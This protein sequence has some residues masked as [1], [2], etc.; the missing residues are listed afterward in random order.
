[1]RRS[2]WSARRIN[3]LRAW[4]VQMAKAAILLDRAAN[5]LRWAQFAVIFLAQ[6]CTAYTSVIPVATLGCVLVDNDTCA[7]LQISGIA[8]AIIG[9][10]VA[11]MDGTIGLRGIAQNMTLASKQINQLARKIDIQLQ[12]DESAR[13]SVDVFSESVAQ[14]YDEIMNTV[15]PLPR[16]I[17]HRE[18]L[19]NLTLLSA[20]IDAPNTLETRP[21]DEV[22]CDKIAYEMERLNNMVG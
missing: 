10:V 18:D 13:T 11:L 3:H 20:Y 7:S 19:I 17:F 9:S 22:V 15:P 4:A 8:F 2:E 6:F 12:R 21:L 1:M 16:F 14:T 5:F